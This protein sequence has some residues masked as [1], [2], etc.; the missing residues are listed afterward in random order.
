M[1]E[2]F[3]LGIGIIALLLSWRFI[4]RKTAL[5][6]FRDELFDLREEVRLY[7][8][9]K[10]YGLEHKTYAEL[11]NLLNSQIRSLEATSFSRLLI[12]EAEMDENEA[13]R[14]SMREDL[15]QRFHTDSEELAHFIHRVRRQAYHYTTGYVLHASIFASALVYSM[16]PFVLFWEVGRHSFKLSKSMID[17]AVMKVPQKA[18]SID[19]V[20][21]FSN[22]KP[23]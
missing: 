8:L 4:V 3:L 14:E 10:G 7:Y 6:H 18:V 20:E 23:A 13:L 11:R 9:E 5:G 16:F 1:N 19:V 15:K 2:S 17:E 12:Y 22:L 21:G